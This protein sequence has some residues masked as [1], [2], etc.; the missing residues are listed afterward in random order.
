M[1]NMKISIKEKDV[2]KMVNECL[3]VILENRAQT[4]R[5]RVE[6]VIR[7]RFGGFPLDRVHPNREENPHGLTLLELVVE[8][9]FGEF[10]SVS[11]ME[12]TPVI[13]LAPMIMRIAFDLG[14]QTPQGDAE[15]LERLRQIVFYLYL[16]YK[17]G[18][19]DLAKTFP[20]GSLETVTY[21][22]LNRTFGRKV[23]E[24]FAE[25]DDEIEKTDFSGN[26]DYEILED[27]DY[28]TAHELGRHSC[29]TSIICYTSNQFVW[30]YY[31]NGGRNKVYVLLKPGWRDLKPVHDDGKEKG[32]AYDTYGLSMIFVIIA[33]S[34]KIA[35]V[36]TRWNHMATF[37]EGCCCNQ[38]LTR[39]DLSKLVHD[40]FSNVFK[41]Y[42]PEELRRKGLR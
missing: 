33:P 13:R 19:I 40:K 18:R 37:K 34:G 4:A 7:S 42:T 16:E 23:D 9:F 41:P 36:N 39:L 20:E 29:P 21:D 8:T 2:R 28:N 27:V 30:N 35:C 1:T 11:D 26:N 3:N 17:Y 15:K 6:A 5:K 31:T 32:S 12:N 25:E 10:F 22:E 38:D 24:K 14:Y